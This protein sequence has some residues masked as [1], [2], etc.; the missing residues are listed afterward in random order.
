MRILKKY[1][2]AIYAVSLLLMSC[3]DNYISSIPD[4]P[5]YLE[6]NLTTT[7]PVFKNSTNQSLIFKKPITA[8]ER[9]GYAG[10]LVY[11]GFDGTYYAFDLC[12]PFEHSST[13]RVS[14]NGLG[15]VVCEKCRTVFDIG[16]GIGNPSSRKRTNL[17]DTIPQTK[18]YLKRYKTSLSGD[19]LYITR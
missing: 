2:L 15:Q 17:P 13:V 8:V 5:V 19:M 3:N 9:V 14:P 12:C 11:T 16:Y 1:Y 18:E 10:V 7:Y 6:L 4:Y